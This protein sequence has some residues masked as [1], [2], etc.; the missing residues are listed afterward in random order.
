MKIHV[1]TRSRV[2]HTKN[3]VQTKAYPTGVHT[4]FYLA[5]HALHPRPALRR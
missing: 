4:P 2:V 1:H 5:L 3:D